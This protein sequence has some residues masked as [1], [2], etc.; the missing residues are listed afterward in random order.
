MPVDRRLDF[1]RVHLQTADVDDAAAPADEMAALAPQLDDVAGVDEAV[2]TEQWAG[3]G[4]QVA[5]GG[6]AGA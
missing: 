2:V 6:P 5:A 4:V 1:L 3:F